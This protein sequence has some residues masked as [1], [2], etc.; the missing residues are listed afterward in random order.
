MPERSGKSVE[1]QLHEFKVSL[2]A[3]AEHPV[4]GKQVAFQR[5]L[6]ASLEDT[7]ES[8]DRKLV[9]PLS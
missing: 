4:N 5:L 3:L 9:V 6:W 7:D 1:G 2:L 8:W